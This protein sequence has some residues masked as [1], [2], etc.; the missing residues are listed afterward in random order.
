M[1]ILLVDDEEAIV[2]VFQRYL[3][4]A[5]YRVTAVVD[6][7]E[8]LAIGSAG[9]IDMLVTDFRMPGMTG[10][11][12]IARLRELHPELPAL[13]VTAFGAEVGVAAADVQVL[14]KPLPPHDLVDAVARALAPAQP[15]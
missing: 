6:P 9:G 7:N 4:R 12:L 2:Y 15:S 13:V 14:N 10:A 1:H 11:E 3:E 5:G 8:A